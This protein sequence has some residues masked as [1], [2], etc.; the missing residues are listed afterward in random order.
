MV[1]NERLIAM[2]FPDK[3]VKRIDE[4][5]R[6]KDMSRS[7][8]IRKLARNYIKDFEVNENEV[9]RDGLTDRMKLLVGK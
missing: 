3:L 9:E 6:I 5:S 2:R 7:S 8:L 1:R 4:I